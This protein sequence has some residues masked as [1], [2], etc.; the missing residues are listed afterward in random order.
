MRSPGRLLFLSLIL[1][2]LLTACPQ[3]SSQVDLAFHFSSIQTAV[4]IS[5]PRMAHVTRSAAIVV[6]SGN[7]SYLDWGLWYQGRTVTVTR[8]SDPSGDIGFIYPTPGSESNQPNLR[9][10]F[11][12]PIL[13]GQQYSFSYEYDVSSSQDQLGW[14]ETFDVSTV[15]VES[16]SVKIILPAGYHVTGVQPTD[17]QVGTEEGRA[18]VIW[19]GLNL[20]GQN[21]VGVTIGFDSSPGS[22]LASFNLSSILSY[23]GV[24]VAVASLALYGA[25]RIRGAGKQRKEPEVILETKAREAALRA[26]REVVPTGLPSLDYLLNGGLPSKSASLLSSPACDERDVIIRRF[27]E[28]GTGSG[29]YCV[30]VGKDTSKVEDLLERFSNLRVLVVGG[31]ENRE[32]VR[33]T[34]KIENLTAVNIDLTSVLQGFR[35]ETG[36]K[37]LCVDITDDLLLV[38]KPPMA[39]KWLSQLIQRA[40]DLG[41]TVL[42]VV[43]SQMHTQA[44]LQAIIDL[45][46]GHIEM[47]EREI[48]DTPKRAIR[49]RKMLRWKFLDTEALLDRD[50]IVQ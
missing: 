18:Q 45:F 32:R 14:S 42:A 9:V 17:A 30:Y 6:D 44:D 11:R 23:A 28:A 34:S 37:R 40:K 26:A 25:T 43:N 41:Y 39:R 27:L 10:L 33:N 50:R 47:I 48:E 4:E 19:G 2:V 7:L 49:I 36:S 21:S 20:S 1:A 16:L 12:N 8:A 31:G 35:E 38:H 29:G 15:R 22:T 3:V 5:S 46:D 24:I 13:Q